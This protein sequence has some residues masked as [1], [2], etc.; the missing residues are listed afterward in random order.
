MTKLLSLFHTLLHILLNFQSL[1]IHNPYQ[2]SMD[3]RYIVLAPLALVLVPRQKVAS[4]R[5]DAKL[6]PERH[7]CPLFD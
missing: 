6:S 4:E 2:L 1:S 7:A 3:W 5:K